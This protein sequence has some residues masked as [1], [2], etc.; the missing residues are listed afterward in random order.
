MVFMDI[1]SKGIIL[2]YVDGVTSLQLDS[3]IADKCKAGLGYNV[4]L[5]P[6][7]GNFL[8]PKPDLSGLQKFENESIISE[9]TVKKPT[10]ETSEAKASAKKPKTVNTAHLK[11]TMNAA[12]P[13]T[14][15]PK[16]VVNTA[17]PKAVLNA[18]KGN[19][20]YAVKASA[21]WVWK[22]KIKNLDHVS[23][24]NSA[25]ITLKKYDYIDA[26][27]RSKGNPKGEKITGKGTIRTGKLDFENLVPRK[28]NMYSVDLKNIFPKG[29]L[30]CLFAK[31]TS[32]ESR[33]WHRRL[34]HLN[35]KTMNKLVKGNLTADSPFPQ[36]PKSSQDTRFKPS[37]D[38]GKKVNEVPRQE[39]KCK[40]QEEKNSVNST[41]RVNAVSST[42]NAASNEV[43]DMDVNS[44]FLYEKIKEEVYVC[45]PLGFEDS[46]FPN[47]VYKVEKKELCNAFEKM[48]HDKF[49]M[50][51][52]GE[53]TFFLG[54]QV[55]QKEDGIFISQ[56]KYVAEI[57]KNF[58]FFEVKTASTPIETQKP[59]LKDEDGEKVDM[60]V[61]SAFLYEKIKEEV[62]VCQP[63][64]FKDSDFPNKVYKVEKCKKQTVVANS[65]TKYEYVVASS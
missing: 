2:A 57:L 49:Q 59:L 11:I 33:I 42:V 9:T 37:N 21:C 20:V 28:N 1:H 65:T 48:M 35:F 8:P 26:Q 27:S 13:R 41:N 17:R 56:D 19:E 51:S 62:Y 10:V 40:Y 12:I 54:L 4:V 34:G 16:A 18:V 6:Y 47:K 50:S 55:K 36:E 15:R 29:G 30:T 32:D 3:Q 58:R 31:A 53:F 38:I 25:S 43:N 24:H 45:Q 39:N 61:N 7:T 46:D 5:P 60:D 22:P 64:R 52:I 63:L 23:R 14:A 44:A